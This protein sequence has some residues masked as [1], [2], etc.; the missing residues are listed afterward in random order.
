MIIKYIPRLNCYSLIIECISCEDI[1]RIISLDYKYFY[2]I[3]YGLVSNFDEIEIKIPSKLDSKL[4]IQNCNTNL[5]FENSIQIKDS[6]K[7]IFFKNRP[8]NLLEVNV[9]L[10]YYI[11][12]NIKNTDLCLKLLTQNNIDWGLYV[13]LSAYNR[14]TEFLSPKK[15]RL[16]NLCKKF[17]E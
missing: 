14:N 16:E 8:I 13:E 12:F 17:F 10:P 2:F 6:L 15:T 7:H 1:S 3:S 9:K 4:V 11:D 5:I